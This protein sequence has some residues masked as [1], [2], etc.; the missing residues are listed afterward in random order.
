MKKKISLIIPVYNTASYLRKCLNSICNQTYK[1]IEIIC[2]DDGSFDGSEKIVDEF[3]K[4]DSRIIVVHKQ[5]QGESNA[6]NTGLK[7]CSGDYVGFVD[8]DD[9]IEPQ[10]YERLIQTLEDNDVD[11]VVAGYYIDNDNDSKRVLNELKIIKEN[12]GRHQLLEYVYKRDCY[13][14]FTGYIWGKIYKKEILYNKQNELILFDESFKMGGDIYYFSNIALN[15]KKI[16]YIDEAYYHYYQRSNSTYHSRDEKVWIDLLSAYICVLR[17]F[18]KENIE[19]DI[20]ILVKRFL[21]YRAGLLA[22]QSFE[23]KN[24]KTLL[25]CQE[26]MRSYS[27]EYTASNI[28]YPDRIKEHNEILNYVICEE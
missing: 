24:I 6:R 14:S 5:N 2:I 22:R 16:S 7:L 28:E 20:L 9:W 15:A 27:K 21:V 13:R 23:N 18:E 11:M 12:F 19:E 8:C 4:K 26:I 17:N 10:M 25:Y 3:S 1:N